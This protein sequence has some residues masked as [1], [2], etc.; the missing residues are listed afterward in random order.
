MYDKYIKWRLDNN[1]FI[2]FGNNFDYIV[3]VVCMLYLRF[4]VVFI[5]L[6]FRF[7]NKYKI[8]YRYMV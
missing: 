5:Y 1:K 6:D 2:I 8:V 4:N 7:K 3:N